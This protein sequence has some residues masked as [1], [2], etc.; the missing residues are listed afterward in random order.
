MSGNTPYNNLGDRCFWR[1]AVAQNESSIFDK[2]WI[3]KFQITKNTKIAT[4]GSCF[5]QHIG[6]WLHENGFNWVPPH[7]EN[8]D[9]QSKLTFDTAQKE[10]FSLNVGNI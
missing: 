8:N 4:A 10:R 2:I 1:T 7:N 6:V 9:T 5:A 3:P